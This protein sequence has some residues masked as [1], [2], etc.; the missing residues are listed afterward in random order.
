MKRVL[1]ITY[2]WPPSGGGGVQRWLKFSK[3]LPEFGWEPVI[4]T[5]ENPE[6]AVID[7]ALVEEVHSGCEILK[8][9][10]W[11]PYQLYR[12]F[13]GKKKSQKFKAGY[14]SEASK[15]GL[16]DRISVFIR[17]NFLIPDP[18][19]FWIK[20]SVKFL[21]KYLREHPVDLIVSTG[22]PHSM[23]LIALQLKKKLPVPW[24][25]DFRDPWTHIDFYE[26]L[27]LTRW[28]HRRHLKLEKAVVTTADKVVT[29]SR[30]WAKQ[31]ENDHSRKVDVVTNGFDPKD[32]KDEE[33]PL[34]EKFTITHIGSFNRDRNPI[35]FWETLGHLYAEDA[36]FR[37]D[38]EIVLIGQ[39][40]TQVVES[41]ISSGLKDSLRLIDFV[42]HKKIGNYLQS[43][44]LLLLPV[45]NTPNSS[46]IIPGKI[47]EY[48]AAR[49]PI[50]AIGPVEGDSAQ[51][52]KELNA[53]VICDFRDAPGIKNNLLKYYR[54]FK[55]NELFLDSRNFNIYSR[56][57][58]AKQFISLYEDIKSSN[59]G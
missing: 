24:I 52:I 44:G 16:K 4:Y 29:V 22:P 33:V 35:Y 49:R 42:E 27:K 6:P 53:G 41:V 30:S 43:S 56:E 58:L 34:S 36:E 47:F 25:A 21:K 23:H 45:N 18:R 15:G 9:R 37:E 54:L 26:T 14:I 10:I 57:M 38:L 48:I 32:F 40:D 2:Y 51:I 17:G 12:I 50:F 19:R 55:N 5:P 20:P 28:A 11:E 7:T 13:T 39:T 3:Y 1:I 46:G 8:T 31:F 59:N